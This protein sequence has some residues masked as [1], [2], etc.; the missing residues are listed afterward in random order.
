MHTLKRL[1]IAPLA[2]SLFIGAFVV[3]AAAK[4]AAAVSNLVL[5]N[6]ILI[7]QNPS[8][9]NFTISG[10]SSDVTWSVKNANDQT[11][12]EGVT[13]TGGETTTIT[14]KKKLPTGYYTFTFS[15]AGNDAITAGFGITGT[16]PSTNTF[17]GTQTLTAHS[18]SFWRD[19]MERITPM[20]KNLGF[21]SRRDSA[22]W[23]EFE[24]TQGNF[25]TTPVIQNVLDIDEQYD[26]N[27]FW[28][29]GRGN[30]LYDGGLVVSTPEGIQAYAEYIHQFLLQHPRIKQV[31]ILNEFNGNS[32]SACGDTGTCYAAIAQ[33]VYEY[34]KPLHPDIT[35]VAGGL[36]GYSATWWDEYFAAGGVNY[37]DA[38]SYHPYNEPPFRLNDLATN[39]TTKIKANNNGV[40]KPIFLSEIGWSITDSQTGN[41]AKVTTEAQQADRVIYSFV[42][43]Q[44]SP[45]IV[46][47][48]W[49]N[50]INYGSTDG[51]Y[52]FGLFR[53]SDT[54]I[55]G[56]QPKPSAIA[57]YVMRKQLD[58]YTFSHTEM[59]TPN[60]RSYVFT[61]TAGDI[62][63]VVWRTDTF[64]SKD[65]ATIPVSVPTSSKKYTTVVN[66]AGQR[67]AATDNNIASL[68]QDVSLS[69]LFITS[70]NTPP[71]A[72]ETDDEEPAGVI[73][74]VPNTGILGFLNRPQP[75][76]L[77]GLGLLSA[78]VIFQVRKRRQDS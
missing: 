40:G 62:Q 23:T 22:Y 8:N 61:N 59:L 42:A 54:N 68:E 6:Q 27:L 74:G 10:A 73:P 60:A 1:L 29:A 37:A 11:L 63:Q 39:L 65:T 41:A 36:A 67:V 19:N 76:L 47:V 33:G 9:V 45:E 77:M 28:T 7:F 25:V 78:V 58:G 72:I 26:M 43:P 35:I 3:I 52:N 15:S 75:L 31:E 13:P 48:N 21:S 24:A 18:G 44:A 38:F 30:P 69:P 2:L 5:T 57:F 32:N 70:S 50:A 55:L 16:T 34:V 66:T 71:P 20:L 53:R 17:Y 56:Y 51:E 4:P 14:L 64:W 12:S 49:Y 46:G